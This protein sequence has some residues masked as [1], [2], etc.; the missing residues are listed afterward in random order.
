MI[1]MR[2]LCG[3]CEMQIP[4]AKRADAIFCGRRCQ[5]AEYGATRRQA[6]IEDKANR[7]PCGYCGATIPPEADIARRFCDHACGQR[8]RRAAEKAARPVQTCPL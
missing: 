5:N 8:A 2:R 6:L 7:P 3:W 1:D 4:D